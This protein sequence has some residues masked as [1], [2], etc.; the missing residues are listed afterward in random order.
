NIDFHPEL[1]VIAADNGQGKTS[2]SD[3]ATV[4][5]GTFIGAF[6]LGKAKHLSKSH[7]RNKI[8]VTVH[9]PLYPLPPHSK[10]FSRR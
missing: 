1:T 7:S 2:V 9:S 5:L 10:P 3:A 4:A 6:D 8:L